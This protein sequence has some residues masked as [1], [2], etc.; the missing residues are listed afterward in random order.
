MLRET[1]IVTSVLHKYFAPVGTLIGIVGVFGSTLLLPL[2]LR[3]GVFADLPDVLVCSVDDPSDEQR[4]DQFVF[5]VSAKLDDGSVLYKSLTSNPVLVKIST[6]GMVSAENL[7]DCD[8]KTV[9]Q[10]RDA[11]RA[12]DF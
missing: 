7:A 9:A 8:G 1:V 3:A 2:D 4:W 12:F 10:L 11:G 5:Y 6:N